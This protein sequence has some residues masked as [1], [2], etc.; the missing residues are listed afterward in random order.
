MGDP[1]CNINN[2]NYT[3]DYDGSFCNQVFLNGNCEYSSHWCS[4]IQGYINA[5][6]VCEE[7]QSDNTE[8]CSNIRDYDFITDGSRLTC[9]IY[10]LDCETDIMTCLDDDGNQSHIT[11]AEVCDQCGIR[12]CEDIHDDNFEDD[13]YNDGCWSQNG[14]HYECDNTYMTCLDE[15]GDETTVTARD[16]CSN[17]ELDHCD[18]IDN[19]TYED[20]QYNYITCDYFYTKEDCDNIGSSMECINDADQRVELTHNEVCDICQQVQECSEITNDNFNDLGYINCDYFGDSYNNE[21][22][23]LHYQRCNGETGQE[24]VYATDICDYCRIQKCNSIKDFDFVSDNNDSSRTCINYYDD[25]Y[26]CE[27]D[28]MQ[29]YDINDN[30]QLELSSISASEVCTDCLNRP[31]DQSITTTPPA[32]TSPITNPPITTTNPPITTTNPPITTTNPPVTITNPPITTT[33]PPITTTNPPITTPPITTTNPPI[34]TTNPPITTTNPPITTTPITTPPITTTNPPIT[35]TNPPIT[36]TNPPITTT[37]PP[38]TTPPITTPPITSP[39]ITTPPITTPSG[40]VQLTPNPTSDPTKTF[41]DLIYSN[42]EIGRVGYVI[43]FCVLL[44]IV[45]FVIVFKLNN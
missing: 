43:I 17:C 41:F 18:T 36:T 21:Q 29:C 8:Y 12:N 23:K 28:T 22:C 31:T 24:Y 19:Y 7:C 14:N 38:I 44:I 35:T 39:P 16:K 27:I 20:D 3:D 10:G 6:D 33:N 2:E 26:N 34:T 13:L 40:E 30:D 32:T 1:P 4:D 37:N 9:D 45:G 11:A 42:G 25:Q 5:S 15:F